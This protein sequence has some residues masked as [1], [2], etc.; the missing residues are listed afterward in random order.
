V[1]TE[2]LLERLPRLALADEAAA[3]PRGTTIRGPAAL[4]VTL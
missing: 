1:A 3:R 4:P 2:V